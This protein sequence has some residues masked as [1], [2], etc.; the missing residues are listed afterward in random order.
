MKWWVYSLYIEHTCISPNIP[1][2]PT[3]KMMGFQAVFER[4]IRMDRALFRSAVFSDSQ[5]VPGSPFLGPRGASGIPLGVGKKRPK[6]KRKKW[7]ISWMYS[8]EISRIVG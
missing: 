8:L 5:V 3:S 2:I 6:K 1:Y 4:C 7:R